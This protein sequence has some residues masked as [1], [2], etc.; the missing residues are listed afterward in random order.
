MVKKLQRIE[1]IDLLR[2]I[3]ILLVL[4]SHF[5]SLYPYPAL[6]TGGSAGNSLFFI[7]C[8]FLITYEDNF[9]PWFGKKTIKLLLPITMINLFEILGPGLIERARN[10]KEFVYLYIWPNTYWFFG[11]ITLFYA[12]FYLLHKTKLIDKKYLISFVTIIVYFLFYIFDTNVNIWSVEDS[13][14]R[15]VYYFYIFIV[16]Y[17]IKE[18]KNNIIYKNK[19]NIFISLVSFGMTIVIKYLMSK[20]IIGMYVQFTTQFLNIVFAYSTLLLFLGL[21]NKYKEKI[22]QRLRKIVTS[23]SLRSF[24]IYIVQFHIIYLCSSLSFPINILV[25]IPT[26]LIAAYILKYICNLILKPLNKSS[27]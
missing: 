23:M 15:F 8:G 21:E 6:A 26:T 1:I 7:I 27:V 3:A 24:E 9:F 5:D 18:S 14:I 16:G 19:K 10:I 22:N 13:K 2:L 11:A 4:N 12:L 20:N 25:V 17:W